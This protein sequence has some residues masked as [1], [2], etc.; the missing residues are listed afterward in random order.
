MLTLIL[1]ARF[2]M[3]EPKEGF[4]AGYQRH[5][6]WHRA[7]ND[8]W[9]WHGWTIITGARI[10]TFV[11]ATVDRTPQEIDTAVSPAEDAADFARN[12]S[13]VGRLISSSIF[14]S[15][16]DLCR[17]KSIDAPFAALIIV[18]GSDRAIK[19]ANI[20]GA[21]FELTSGGDAPTY[22]I[23]RPARS[24]SAA[25]SAPPIAGATIEAMRYRKDL[26]YVPDS[27]NRE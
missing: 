13:P 18:H 21:C 12:V 20:D 25:L 27:K 3:I 4:D 8:P 24:L 15:R 1:L 26:T 19:A 6:E 5:L 7:H 11:D 14:R 16:A 22:L 9:V 23:I 2:T 10:G 17:T